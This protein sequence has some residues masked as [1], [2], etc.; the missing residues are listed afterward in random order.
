MVFG[1]RSFTKQLVR[2][3]SKRSAE[4]PFLLYLN[5]SFNNL[6]GEVSKEGAFRNT[7]TIL[8]GN[9]KL[10]GGVLELQLPACPSK[11]QHR[12]RSMI[13]N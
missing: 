7:S 9:T 12:E 13:S 5:L 10:C 1:F 4:T 3:N 8:V 2:T 6:E 11:D